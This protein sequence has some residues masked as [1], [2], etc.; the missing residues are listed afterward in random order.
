MRYRLF[1]FFLLINSLVNAQPYYELDSSLSEGYA[2]YYQGKYD[3]AGKLF[4]RALREAQESGNRKVEAEAYRLLGE[5]NRA[6]MNRPYALKYLDKAENIFSEIRDDYGIAST[7]NRKAAVYFETGDSLLCAKYLQSSLKIARD[8]HFRDL[9]YNSL[10]IQGAIEYVK[11][12]DYSA[13][14]H[15][16]KEALSIAQELN[17][18]EDFPYMYN[19]LSRIYQEIGLLDS[20]LVYGEASLKIGEEYNI[21]AYIAA[22]CGRLSLIYWDKGDFEKAYGYERRFNEIHD[23]LNQESKDKVVAELVEKYQNEKHELAIERQNAQLR[24]MVIAAIILLILLIV[25]LVLF[26]TNRL[27]R[28]KQKE[29]NQKIEAQNAVL[30]ENNLV[31]DRL[32][33]VLSHDLRSPVAA[34][35]TAL[36]VIREGFVSPADSMV[37]LEE[38]SVRVERTTE[39]L[40]NLL[41][42]IKN[43]LN[44]I[45]PEKVEVNIKSNVQEVLDLMDP[46]IQQKGLR[47]KDNIDESFVLFAD[48]EMIRLVLR[49]IISNSVKFSDT[50][51]SIEISAAKTDESII[52]SINDTGDGMSDEVL[53]N[54]FDVRKVGTLG[55]HKE[56]GMGIGLSLVRD[57]VEANN[58]EIHINSELG[59]GTKVQLIFPR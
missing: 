54:I 48:Q 56:S 33:S 23:T 47:I 50:G 32:L 21:R 3:A 51:A 28:I 37:L 11:G 16:L 19:N 44:K 38:L 13:A 53:A 34:I 14:I 1:V 31:K 24:Y 22:A 46:A 8:N 4:F 40:D 27:H 15:S 18:V 35:S 10:T 30:E 45:A 26:R 7:K 5:V 20:S 6:S 9:E 52:L 39:L 49:N 43:Q 42:W 57:F 25:M 41:Y 17:K 59:K 29:I 36:M 55:T 2:L 58:G 12:R